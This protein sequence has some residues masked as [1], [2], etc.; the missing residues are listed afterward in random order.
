MENKICKRCRVDKPISEYSIIIRKN[1]EYNIGK[2]KECIRQLKRVV[3][4]K[5]KK[6]FFDGKNKEC[7][8]CSQIKNIKDFANKNNK[9][10]FRCKQC[11]NLWYRNYYKENVEK[12][13]LNTKKYKEN[14]VF[15]WTRHGLSKD[16]YV[17]LLNKNEG[18]CHICLTSEDLYIDHDH[19]CCTGSTSCGKCVRG[20]LCRLCNSML[21]MA[22][23]NQQVLI[24]ASKYLKMYNK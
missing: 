21:G 19:A 22:K 5:I 12:V 10:A 4:P 11:H 3:D 18:K 2:C 1:K 15:Q 17:L 8:D 24:S 9:P 14:N 13:K 23:D 6:L 16:E 7:S 20:L